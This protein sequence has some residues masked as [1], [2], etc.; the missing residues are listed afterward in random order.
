MLKTFHVFEDPSLFLR[1]VTPFS[2][3]YSGAHRSLF[4]SSQSHV[5]QLELYMFDDRVIMSKEYLDQN[6]IED[7]Y[8]LWLCLLKQFSLGY[9][10]DTGG[11]RRFESFTNEWYPK[12]EDTGLV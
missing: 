6:S 1:A 8:Q 4:A 9:G 7:L 5:F 2:L 11:Y 3:I 10:M 12:F